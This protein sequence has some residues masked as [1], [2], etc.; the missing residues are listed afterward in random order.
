MTEDTP[1][2]NREQR[3]A[4]KFH[5]KTKGRQDNLHTQSENNTGFLAGPAETLA[6]G[7]KDGAIATSTNLGPTSL[8]GPG[9]GGATESE[10]VPHNE[11][12]HLGNQANS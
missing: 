9:T 10:P 1:P 8:V 5:R 7:P 2:L 4:R 3:R 11:A 12:V 6:D